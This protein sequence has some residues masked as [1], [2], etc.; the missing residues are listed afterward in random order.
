MIFTL[1]T[2]DI[3]SFDDASIALLSL[4]TGE[5]HILL[6]GG[7]SARYSPTD[8]IIY[9]RAGTLLAVPFDEAGLEV[10]GAPVQV[11]EGVSTSPTSGPAQFSL[12]RD[13]SLIY[14]PGEPTGTDYRVVWVDRTGRATPLI[15]APRA[16]YHARLSPDGRSLAVSVNHANTSLWVYDTTRGALTRLVSG[17]NN[18]YPIWTPDGEQ[19]TFRSDPEGPSDIFWT[20]A[21]GSG[22][23]ERLSD[24]EFVQ[25]PESWSPDGQTLAFRELSPETGY[26][27]WMLSLDGER[28]ARP[29]LQSSSN[30]SHAAFSPNG[31]WIAYTSDESGRQEVYV[32]SFPEPGAKRQVSTEGG[33]DPLW[34]PNGR[35]L[36][37]RREGQMI[38]VETKAEGEL[39]L[40]TPRLLFESDSHMPQESSYDVSADGERFVMIDR[41][42]S[43]PPPRELVLVQ[44]FAE[45]V[46]RLVPTNN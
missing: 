43:V 33:F 42:E 15:D 9:A 16:Y 6:E 3:D 8:H 22:Q 40:G 41:G 7:S 11:L 45:E 32:R 31:R 44:N 28:A 37:Y 4:E 20:A 10:T 14:A 2:G 34:N 30:E 5:I 1:A 26:D 18:W 35:E 24:S 38:A 21:D 12:T 29:F 13:G 19:V 27:I 46:K 17:F 36:F 39:V 23:P 25:I